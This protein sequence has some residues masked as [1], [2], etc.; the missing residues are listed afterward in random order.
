MMKDPT[1]SFLFIFTS[2]VGGVTLTLPI[3][4]GH[5]CKMEI[6]EREGKQCHITTVVII[7]AK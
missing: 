1:D 7:S 3:P 6:P 4:H 2:V 5:I